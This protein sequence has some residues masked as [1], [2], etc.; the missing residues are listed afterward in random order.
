MCIRDRVKITRASGLWVIGAQK[1]SSCAFIAAT[2]AVS[3]T[4][5]DVY[6][7][8]QFGQTVY[9]SAA[10]LPSSRAVTITMSL[11]GA[12]VGLI[13]DYVAVGRGAASAAGIPLLVPYL[14]AAAN[15]SE[16]LLSLI[17]I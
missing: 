17:H 13:I 6:K 11:I 15:R 4:H 8:Q 12:A 14:A 10:P 3:Y 1:A 16:P 5:L 7:R 9:V 2:K